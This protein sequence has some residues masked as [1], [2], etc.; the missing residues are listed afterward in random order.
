MLLSYKPKYK[1]AYFAGVA[2]TG[3]SGLSQFH[4]MCGGYAAGSDRA[5]DRGGAK[6]IAGKLASAGVS[7]VAQDGEGLT[8]DFDVV[9]CIYGY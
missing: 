6:D 9:V 4:V 7:I 2:G 5:I 1:S 8:K 3:M